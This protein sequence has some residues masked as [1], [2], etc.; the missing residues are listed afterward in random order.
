MTWGVVCCRLA[1]AIQVH[2]QTLKSPPVKSA[3][4][5]YAHTLGRPALRSR[6]RTIN[7]SL[8]C[9]ILNGQYNQKCKVKTISLLQWIVHVPELNV[10]RFIWGRLSKNIC[11]VTRN[12]NLVW[13]HT[14]STL[15]WNK[16]FVQC[17]SQIVLFSGRKF[18]LGC[19]ETPPISE[20]SSRIFEWS[21]LDRPS[22]GL[23]SSIKSVVGKC[24]SYKP[25]KFI[26]PIWLIV[27]HGHS[28]VLPFVTKGNNSERWTPP[29]WQSLYHMITKVWLTFCMYCQNHFNSKPG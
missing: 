10:A 26:S 21:I 14:A 3:G 29:Q 28:A 7:P 16:I 9:S 2:P 6:R 19:F 18:H 1:A 20:T 8:H 5:R 15:D 4:A 25:S 11:E 22:F 27:S 17:S 24:F 12:E 13:L 23:F